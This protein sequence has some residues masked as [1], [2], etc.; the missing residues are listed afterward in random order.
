MLTHSSNLNNDADDA[1]LWEQHTGI[2]GSEINLASI[3]WDVRTQ[4]TDKKFVIFP[5]DLAPPDSLRGDELLRNLWQFGNEKVEL[6]LTTIPWLSHL[7]SRHFRDR[8]H[9]FDW[10]SDLFANGDA[11]SERAKF[12]IDSW[13]S[14]YGHFDSFAWRIETTTDRLWNWIKCSRFLY[15]GKKPEQENARLSALIRQISYLEEIVE[16]THSHHA[17]WKAACVFVAHRIC[18]QITVGLEQAIKRLEKECYSQFLVDGCHASRSPSATF[19]ALQDLAVLADLFQQAKTRVPRFI[20]ELHSRLF[21]ALNFFRQGDDGIAPFNGGNEVR[22]ERFDTVLRTIDTWPEQK[23]RLRKAGFYR[24]ERGDSLLILDAGSSPKEEFGSLA[25]AGTFGIEFS[26]GV[27]RLVTSCGH[28]FEVCPSLQFEVRKTKAH[29]TLCLGGEDSAELVRGPTRGLYSPK[30]DPDIQTTFI[31][32]DGC[33]WINAQHGGYHKRFYLTHHRRLFMNSDGSQI[34][35]ED[36]VIRPNSGGV[37]DNRE[38]IDFS[39]RFHIH[40]N[41]TVSKKREGIWLEPNIGLPWTF[42][43]SHSSVEIEPSIYIARDSIEET[44][45]IVI[46]GKADPTGVSSKPPNCVRW[47]FK[48]QIK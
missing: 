5:N 31:E 19:S 17:K 40:P 37:K 26:D 41:T 10:L 4:E 23:T 32:D 11:G 1:K 14:V 45:Q 35:G 8:L 18:C 36:T 47:T 22:P 3:Q 28:S 6:D 9:R 24:M 39:I 15:T 38:P 34:I 42:L 29:S 43:T 21:S 16:N 27:S 46:Y 2:E 44:Q 25:H 20:I 13:I 33:V 12:L 30:I 48:K 7:P